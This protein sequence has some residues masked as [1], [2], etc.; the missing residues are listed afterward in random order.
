[1]NLCFWQLVNETKCV[2]GLPNCIN[3]TAVNPTPMSTVWRVKQFDTRVYKWYGL[4]YGHTDLSH[5][6]LSDVYLSHN[7]LSH[8]YLGDKY[9]RP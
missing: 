5:N 6:H 9:M 3:P 2:N 8:N 7:C 1:M 4:G